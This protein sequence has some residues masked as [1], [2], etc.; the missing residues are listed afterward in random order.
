MTA[1]L[2]ACAQPGPSLV[3]LATA[4]GVGLQ[5]LSPWVKPRSSLVQTLGVHLPRTVMLVVARALAGCC[6]GS[7]GRRE[8]WWWHVRRTSG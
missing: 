5:Q 4:R 7:S 8:W 3:D 2:V 1:R 6:A